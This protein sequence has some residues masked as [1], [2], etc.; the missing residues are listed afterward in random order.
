MHI[1]HLACQRDS[2]L[3]FWVGEVRFIGL[4]LQCWMHSQE[5]GI[6]MNE[7]E[8]KLYSYWNV[9]DTRYLYLMRDIKC[10]RPWLAN[11]WRKTH[12]NS[13]KSCAVN[14]AYA[15]YQLVLWFG[16]MRMRNANGACDFGLHLAGHT[17]RHRPKE[18]DGLRD[19]WIDRQTN[20]DS[21][22]GR[23]ASGL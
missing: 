1:L 20:T 23:Q 19:R 3:T 6:Q 5:N 17:R 10:L 8:S 15:H 18:I 14:V 11:S 7:R 2:S 9:C 4:L 16:H 12:I 21:Q 13:G 22:R